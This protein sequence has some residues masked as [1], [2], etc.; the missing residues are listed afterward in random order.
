MGN[1]NRS[2]GGQGPAGYS[3]ASTFD[4][5]SNVGPFL[6]PTGATPGQ[7][8]TV[9][10]AAPV[11]STA[12][13]GPVNLPALTLTQPTPLSATQNV[14]SAQV[15]ASSGGPRSGP[16]TLQVTAQPTLVWSADAADRAALLVAFQVFQAQLEALEG[17]AGSPLVKGCAELVANRVASSLPLRY[18][19]VLPY[20]HGFDRAGQTIDIAPGMVLQVAW[21]G[22]QYCDGPGGP[23][24][25]SNGFVTTGQSLL[26]VVRR[27]D[28]TLAFDSFS[29]LFAPG[30]QLQPAN[31]AP[32]S[33]SPV[34]AGGPVDL[35][36]G[37]NARRHFK[38]VWP[39]AFP[40][41]NST[42]SPG[43]TSLGCQ[44]VGAD[45]FVDLAASVALIQS[46]QSGCITQADG[47]PVVVIG[48]TGRVT[49]VPCICTWT[50]G[51]PQT[52]AVGTTLR[53]AAQR[54]A[55]LAPSQLAD[56][57]GA[58]SF[59]RWM[60]LAPKPNRQDDIYGVSTIDFS[61]ADAATGPCGDG[62]DL[63]LLK[64]DTLAFG[65]TVAAGK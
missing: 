26:D 39:A 41:S 6:L 21:A 55:D 57:L 56:A 8:I 5:T 60:Q 40:A 64:G 65:S 61:A 7:P 32:P 47:K 28:G 43:A 2:A 46:G 19:E 53:N 45:T 49:I 18:D 62:F 38:L 17:V 27:P 29:G 3:I 30:V 59:S 58:S 23:G 20:F 16:P 48:F 9:Y 54:I 4:G 51:V 35:Q 37:G 11:A 31:P 1:T 63:P 12:A 36:L 52:V 42:E 24:E 10:L 44:L 13:A 33:N 15:V 14:F 50:N 34:Q 22:Y 25:G